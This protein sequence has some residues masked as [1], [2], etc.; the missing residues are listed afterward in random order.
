M[1]IEV[2][3]VRCEIEHYLLVMFRGSDKRRLVEKQMRMRT[4]VVVGVFGLRLS[5]R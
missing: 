1:F 4:T 2:L 5:E 3:D